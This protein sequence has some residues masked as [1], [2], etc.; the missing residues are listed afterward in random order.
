MQTLQMN[1]CKYEFIYDAKCSEILISKL[2]RMGSFSLI[3]TFIYI[4][5]WT[6]APGLDTVILS[7]I[8][9]K[10]HGIWTNS[11]LQYLTIFIELV[12]FMPSLHYHLLELVLINHIPL[13]VKWRI[14]FAWS[15]YVP[16]PRLNVRAI[17]S[18]FEVMKLSSLPLSFQ[19][20][21]Q[22]FFL[23]FLH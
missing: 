6:K 15:S 12:H 11:K 3:S 20:H 22:S 19:L 13:G 10:L 17:H 9:K 1:V 16:C 2:F 14:S 8:K 18:P 4:R 23:G 5:C 7:Q 21:I